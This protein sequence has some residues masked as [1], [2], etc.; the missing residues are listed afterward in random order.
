MAEP[1]L[2]DEAAHASAPRLI[3]ADNERVLFAKGDRVYARTSKVG[4][5]PTE[6]TSPVRYRIYRNAVA[7]RDPTTGTILAYEAQFLGAA[8]LARGESVRDVTDKDG[9][10][11][12]ELIPATL[13]IVSNKEEMRAGDR[14]LPE[15]RREFPTYVPRAPGRPIEG[16]RVMAMYGNNVASRRSERCD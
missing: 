1:V 12:K 4:D 10:P 8:D 7:L 9:K 16:V 3:G 13:D 2:V 6:K 11:I 5:L 14:L 15:P